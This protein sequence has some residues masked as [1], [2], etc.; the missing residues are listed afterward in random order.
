MFRNHKYPLHVGRRPQGKAR[1]D[2]AAS[3]DSPNIPNLVIETKIEPVSMRV[4][5]KQV[6]RFNTYAVKKIPRATRDDDFPRREERSREEKILVA[7]RIPF[8][9]L[10]LIKPSCSRS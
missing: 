5:H 6:G 8:D 2:A 4:P 10:G 3:S 7:H 1:E 9:A